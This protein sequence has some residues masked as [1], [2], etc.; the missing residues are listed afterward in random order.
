MKE[1]HVKPKEKESEGLTCTLWR[2]WNARMMIIA[3]AFR[4]SSERERIAEWV[5]RKD[6]RGYRECVS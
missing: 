6:N 3:L 1:N 4:A 5:Y 2:S